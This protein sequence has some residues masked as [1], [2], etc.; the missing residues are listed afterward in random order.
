MCKYCEMQ[1]TADDAGTPMLQGEQII[2]E[3]I[4]CE[5]ADGDK[6]LLTGKLEIYSG[7]YLYFEAYCEP[8]SVYK[9]IEIQFCPMCGRKLKHEDVE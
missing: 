1:I 2:D 4:E 7:N 9:T 6:E 5:W 8:Y 3:T